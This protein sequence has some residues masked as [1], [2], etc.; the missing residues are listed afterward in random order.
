MWLSKAL[1]LRAL[2]A[3]G[4]RK[5]G[6]FRRELPT[7]PP[8]F[9]VIAMKTVFWLLIAVVGGLL[10]V[11]VSETEKLKVAYSELDQSMAQN[12]K[13][14]A[15]LLQLQRENIAVAQTRAR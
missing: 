6:R 13:V 2:D 14:N 15:K 4:R 1:N 11:T 7:E 3:D 9:E 10:A 5:I 8:A 12:A